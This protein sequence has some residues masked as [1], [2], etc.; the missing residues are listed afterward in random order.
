LKRAGK[1]AEG[2]AAEQIAAKQDAFD[3]LNTLFAEQ[4]CTPPHKRVTAVVM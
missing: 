4:V 3:Q 2:D 1:K